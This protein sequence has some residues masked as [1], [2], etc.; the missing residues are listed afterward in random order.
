MQGQSREAVVNGK[1]PLQVV[2]MAS[3]DMDLDMEQ[4]GGEDM[5]KGAWTPEEDALL[6]KLIGIYGTKNWSVVAAGIKGR[7]GKSCRLR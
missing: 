7:S 1:S 4:Y 6:T 2:S 5:K 3:D